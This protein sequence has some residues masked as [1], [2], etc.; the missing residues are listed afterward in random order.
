MEGTGTETKKKKNRYEINFLKDM[1][2]DDGLEMPK[3]V[4]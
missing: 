2:S 3:H 4:A 1:T